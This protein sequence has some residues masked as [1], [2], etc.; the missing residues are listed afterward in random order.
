MKLHL[1]T[2]FLTLAALLLVGWRLQQ[3]KHSH[4]PHGLPVLLSHTCSWQESLSQIGD[5][6]Q[7]IVTKSDPEN[8][9]INHMRFDEVGL[10]KEFAL[11]YGTRAE[12]LAWFQGDTEITY[13]DAVRVMSDM[14]QSG[15]HP[16][17]ALISPKD[18]TF[19]TRKA[20]S[21][22]PCPFKK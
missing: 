6:R 9:E 20:P 16:A 1:R 8:V 2:A 12:R 13:G 21:V 18:E 17:I 3:A 11:I 14:Y 5:D 15:Y 19:Y 4:V 10:Q 7:I 22:G